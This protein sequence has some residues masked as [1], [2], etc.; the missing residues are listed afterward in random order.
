MGLL[1][2]SPLGFGVLTG[3]FLDGARPPSARLVRW[4]RFVRYSGAIAEQATASYVAIAR[5]HGLNPAQMALAFVNR[6]P[7][8][9]ST[10]IGATTMEQLAIN[11]ASIDV[12]LSDEVMQ[13]I[14]TVHRTHPNP[15]P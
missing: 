15:A 9:T 5:E 6:Q 13:A 7:F 3:K 12:Q 4:S 11:L 14:E 10:L 2:Y 1:A 8:V